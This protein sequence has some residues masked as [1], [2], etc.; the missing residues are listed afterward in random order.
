MSGQW[1][2]AGIVEADGP[3]LQYKC[4]ARVVLLVLFFAVSRTG[5]IH[6]ACLRLANAPC[7]QAVRNALAG[8]MPSMPEMERRLNQA[9][10]AKL[11]KG[12]LNKALIMAIDVTE[13]C[14]YG[15]PWRRTKE[16]RRGKRRKGTSRF[17]CYAT[18][19]AVERG[20]R[21][22]LAITYVWKGDKMADVVRRLLEQARGHGLKIRFLLLDRGF[23]GIDVVECLK[24]FHCPFL[25]PVVHRGRT[26]KRPL[27][28]L[29]GTRRFL[30]WKKS[31]YSTHEMTNRKT[32]T[33]VNIS[34]AYQRGSRRG[35]KPRRMVFAYWGF[36]P[37]SPAWVCQTYR[38]RYGIEAS[39]RQMNQ[40]R[41]RTCSRDPR[42]RLLLVG[43]ALLLRNLW[44]WLHYAVLGRRRGR[45]IQLQLRLLRFKTLL[46][47]L[48][49]SAEALF[50]C[51]ERA[52]L[53]DPP[54][55]A[56]AAAA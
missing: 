54:P 30:S 29:K 16:L 49:R 17:H 10:R 15:R 31:G 40:G 2:L 11:P 13:I 18:L 9:L 25:M 24:S 32:K 44:V 37:G 26:S 42:L 41:I 35:S 28:Q 14:Y 22:T 19:Y 55:I 39:Y 46:L 53:P 6:D 3:G 51:A 21:S 36:R 27:D 34:V 4:A 43:I 7:D 38:S 23:Y 12:L 1:H 5:S 50:G 8:W 45:N 20:Q 48:Q 52:Q 47:K 33:K 56:K